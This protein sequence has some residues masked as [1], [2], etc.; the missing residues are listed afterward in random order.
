M[1]VRAASPQPIA[2]RSTRSNEIDGQAQRS[3]KP[4][5]RP[6]RALEDIS[7]IRRASMITTLFWRLL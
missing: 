4:V 7:R 6:P 1:P 5:I 3:T 2:M